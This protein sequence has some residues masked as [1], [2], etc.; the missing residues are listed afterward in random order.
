MPH[1]PRRSNLVLLLL[2][3]LTLLVVAASLLITAELRRLEQAF[4]RTTGA[5]AAEVRHKL[6]ANEAVLSGLSAF[7]LAVERD[8]RSATERYAAA[9]IAAHPHIYQIELARQVP[10]AEAEALAETLRRNGAGD[11]TLKDF[12]TLTGRP[13]PAL[14]PEDDTWPIVIFYPDLPATRAIH[15]LRLETVDHLAA[16]LARARGHPQAVASPALQLYEG[17]TGYLL[18]QVIERPADDHGGDSPKLFGSTMA[19]MLLIKSA[20]LLPPEE[21]AGLDVP[22]GIEAALVG[23]DGAQGVLL[24]RDRDPGTWL[25]RLLLPAFERNETVRSAAQ[26]V[27]IRFS[28][29]QR[30]QDVLSAATMVI[31][32]L[33]LT[34]AVLAPCLLLRHYRA[35]TRAGIE[36]EH[37]AY[38]ATHDVLTGLPNRYLLADRFS[39]AV[40]SWQRNGNRFAV[41]LIDLDHFK[42][43]N[44]Q[45]GHEAGDQVLRAAA[46]RMSEQLRSCDTVARYGGD[47]FIV[48]LTNVLDAEDAR[49]VGEKLLGAVSRPVATLAGEL[50]LSCSVGVALCPDHGT[51]LDTLRRRADLAMY[52][53]KQAGRRTVVVSPITQH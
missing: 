36:H 45:H 48:L 13:P 49:Q 53:A 2:A 52:G 34:A 4:Q 46:E 37:S 26:Q 31:F 10:A 51:D 38:L 15:G 12:A 50:P 33:L 32:G 6:Y 19:A 30:L 41:I 9:V 40:H 24:Q 16:T 3:W 23:S 8:D 27:R 43:I 17:E 35:L 29:Q 5:L 22:L 47:E 28:Q 7:L 44:D 20:A 39:H 25:D 1:R 14:P 11:L 21:V 18:L 42:A